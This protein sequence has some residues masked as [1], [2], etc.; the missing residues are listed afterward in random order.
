M[1]KHVN[2]AELEEFFTNHGIPF[3][4]KNT[5]IVYNPISNTITA[6]NTSANLSKMAKLV[7]KNCFL[8]L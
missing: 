4:G 5:T 3:D 8:N 1:V 7:Q 2:F 6:R